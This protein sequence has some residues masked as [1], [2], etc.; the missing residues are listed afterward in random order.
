MPTPFPRPAVVPGVGAPPPTLSHEAPGQPPLLVVQHL[1]RRFGR[2]AALAGLTFQVPAGR[3]LG[4]IGPNGSG[5]TTLMRILGVL[6]RPTAGTAH[7]HGRD[8]RRLRRDAAFSVGYM[9]QQG[10]IY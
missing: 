3:G 1:A 2:R 10:G 7:V 6:L 9:P 4:V 5:K 8:V